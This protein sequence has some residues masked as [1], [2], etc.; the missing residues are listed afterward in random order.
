MCTRITIGQRSRLSFDLYKVTIYIR[1]YCV[2]TMGLNYSCIVRR[3]GGEGV[4]YGKKK[5][6]N[7]ENINYYSNDLYSVSER[8]RFINNNDDVI[9]YN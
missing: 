8:F 6:K 5:K 1:I 3:N 7:T 9:A 2:C 4:V